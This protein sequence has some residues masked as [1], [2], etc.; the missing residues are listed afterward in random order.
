MVESN[1]NN[2][3]NIS[4]NIDEAESLDRIETE[5][6]FMMMARSFVNAIRSPNIVDEGTRTRLVDTIVGNPPSNTP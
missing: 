1:N 2:I 6:M 3:H 5:L 4:S